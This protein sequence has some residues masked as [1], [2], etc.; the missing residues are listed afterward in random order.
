[1]FEILE[2]LPYCCF[3]IWLFLIFTDEVN[4]N[5]GSMEFST[6]KDTKSQ[7]GPMSILIGHRL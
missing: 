4:L 2:H 5:C 3:T 7:D 1:M 6:K